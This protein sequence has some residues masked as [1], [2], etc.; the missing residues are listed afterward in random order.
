MSA[1]K[2]HIFYKVFSK[3]KQKVIWKWESNV[4]PPE[5]PDNV[6][7]VQWIPQIDLLAQ[8]QVKVFISHCGAGGVYEAMYQGVPIL[9]I[10]RK[11]YI[12]ENYEFFFLKNKIYFFLLQPIYG[13]QLANAKQIKNLGWSI[14]LDFDNLNETVLYDGILELLT[15]STYKSTVQRLS[16]LFRDRPMTPLQLAI[17]WIEYV[18]RYDGAKHMQSPAVHLNFIQSNSIDVVLFFVIILYV[19]FKVIVKIVPI[20]IK[21]RPLLFLT[22]SIIAYL[23]LPFEFLLKE[24]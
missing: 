1:E 11:E 12:K 2:I 24:K 23:I 16:Q 5:K 6:Y 17:Y 20:I 8:P 22:L 9:G 3:L 10:V 21:Y 4:Y 18:I 7:M 14:T 13:D 15:N 19:A